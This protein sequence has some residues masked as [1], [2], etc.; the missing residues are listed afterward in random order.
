MAFG[1]SISDV[2]LLT[3]LAWKTVQNTRKACGEHDD[4]TRELSSLHIVLR[5]LEQEI[6][7]PE[8]PLNTQGDTS[9]EDVERILSGCQKPLSL[10]DR[11]V[12]NY[13]LLSQEERSVKKL[14]RQVRFGNG[15]IADLRDIRD[16]LSG[17][18]NTLTLYLN[19]VSTGSIGRVEKQME[20]AGGDIKDVK[21]AVNNLTARLLMG[22]HNEGSVLTSRTNDDKTVWKDF[23]RGLLKDGFNSSF[24]HK[25]KH[26]I[27]SYLRASASRHVGRGKFL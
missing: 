4:L 24:L 19:L 9:K 1:W 8:S 17:H 18:T 5:R 20:D 6:A 12:A 26:M 23:R 3:R 27:Q 2:A 11:L 21:T 13:S 7:R 16:K 10:L 25:H 22:S 15:E 14:W